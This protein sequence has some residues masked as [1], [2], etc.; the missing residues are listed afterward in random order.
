[1]INNYY[2]FANMD[3]NTVSKKFQSNRRG[4]FMGLNRWMYASN[5]IPDYYNRLSLFLAKMIYDGSYEAHSLD[6]KKMI[7]YDPKKDK[8]FNYYF[9]EREKYKNK[10]GKYTPAPK[11]EKFNTQ[12][13]LYNL[14]ISELNKERIGTGRQTYSDDD[15]ID[16]AYS[17]K[18]RTSFKSFTDTAYGY[19]DKD[20][21]AQ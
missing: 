4:L 17:E 11:D 18:E 13:N 9:Q 20:S 7:I 15:I 19:Y 5:T 16:Q 2:G 12:R 3:I 14:L 21:Q 10:S 1:M 8:R 6:D